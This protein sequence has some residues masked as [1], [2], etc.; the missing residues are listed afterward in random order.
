MEAKQSGRIPK[1][2]I[3]KVEDHQNGRHPFF[4]VNNAGVSIE[5]IGCFHIDQHTNYCLI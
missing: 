4:L 5:S 1:C 3:T 2:K